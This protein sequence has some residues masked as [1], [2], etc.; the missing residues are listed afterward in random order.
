MR[1]LTNQE[2][3]TRSRAIHGN[4]YGYAFVKY[5]SA[6]TKVSIYCPDHGMF[7]QSANHHMRG[8]NC[9]DCG[10]IDISLTKRSNKE[11]FVDKANKIHGNK[12]RYSKVDY[13]NAHTKVV[14]ECPEHGDF[15]Q[16]PNG[17]ISGVGCAECSG[18]KKHNNESFIEKAKQIHGDKYQYQLVE[19]ITN[20]NKVRIMCPEHGVFDQTPTNHLS[21]RGC[22]GCMSCG[23][24]RTKVGFLYVLRSECGRY[25]KIGI[26]NKPDQRHIQL[27]RTTPFSFDCIEL[28][29]GPGDQIANLEKELLAEYQPAGFTETFDGSTEWRLWSD[30]IRHKLI[31]F[32][33]KELTN[34]PV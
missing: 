28:I 16:T 27:S 20:K 11:S 29:E 32:M 15:E 24:D 7:E 8:H 19:Y 18:K 5:V 21:G 14:I 25:M 33:N 10:L 6:H 4:K 26:T 34:G 17:H 3:I 2:F 30:S 31:S 9:P 12:Y 23:F 13:V 22:P 1:K